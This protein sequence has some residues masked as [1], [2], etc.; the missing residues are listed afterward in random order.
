[1]D[2]IENQM[3]QEMYNAFMVNDDLFGYGQW[4]TTALTDKWKTAFETFK[5]QKKELSKYL[6][7]ALNDNWFSPDE[8]SH[9]FSTIIICNR[10]I[11]KLHQTQTKQKPI[12]FISCSKWYVIK[13]R[14]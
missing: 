11:L 10:H 4:D 12:L 8:E 13:R 1:M 9:V 6:K 3:N 14:L 2:D 5:K 7:T